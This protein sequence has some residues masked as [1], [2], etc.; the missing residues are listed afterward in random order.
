V[1][2]LVAITVVLGVVVAGMVLGASDEEAAPHA[3]FDVT[4]DAE[5]DRIELVH[6][7]GDRLTAGDT[8]IIL[9]VGDDRVRLD[10]PDSET[11]L[12]SGY[13][14]T[15]PLDGT[16]TSS[17][18]W[19]TFSIPQSVDFDRGETV[20]VTL[21][22]VPSNK[23][24]FEDTVTAWRESG[25]GGLFSGS[26]LTGSPGGLKVLSG[27]GQNVTT[28]GTSSEPLALGPAAADLDGDGDVDVPYVAA[29]GELKLVDGSGAVTT[30]AT[31]GDFSDEIEEDKSRLAV[32]TWKGSGPA[33]FFANENHDA[34]YR[35]SASGTPTEVA[36]PGDGVQSVVGVGDIDG[37]G[38]DE[39][40]F[41]DGS[42]HLQYL[43]PDGTTEKLTNGGTGSNV[44]IGSGSLADFDGDGTVSVVVT[45]GSNNIKLVGATSG[46]G[47]RT[48]TTP[49]A[50]KSPPTVADVDGDS[51]AEIIYL[52]KSDETFRYVDD[53]GGSEVVRTLS[54]DSGADVD[55]SADSGAAS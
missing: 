8:R 7:A 40:V 36:T 23:P 26:V 49:N 50:E 10:P 21:Y 47:T 33:V 29:S 30:I 39:L 13:S 55:G 54:D 24:V 3:D 5:A 53:V 20:E 25:S 44:G 42:Q 41:A 43:E 46:E 22:D 28:L 35:V 2:L 45:D 4:A 31:D 48:L 38:T 18:R 16:S 19:S 14:V 52:A 11:S 15:I 37:D 6:L 27:D 51:D 32:G 34:L 17:G 9:S 1:V 12:K